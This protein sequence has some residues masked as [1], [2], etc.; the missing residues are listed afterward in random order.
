MDYS[1]IYESMNFDSVKNIVKDSISEAGLQQ[2]TFSKLS[3]FIVDLLDLYNKYN[4]MFYKLEIEEGLLLYTYSKRNDDWIYKKLF[5]T[6]YR[7]LISQ[8]DDQI[9]AD[10][11]RYAMRNGYRG[12]IFDRSHD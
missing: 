7:K 5:D 9:D 4:H 8:N 10:N 6:L 1:K 12:W 11:H 2:F 3:P